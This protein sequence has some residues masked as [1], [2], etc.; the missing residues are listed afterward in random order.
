MG[1]PLCVKAAT[2]AHGLVLEAG[3]GERTPLEQAHEGIELRVETGDAGEVEAGEFLTRK[4]SPADQGCLFE[5]AERENVLGHAGTLHESA[6]ISGVRS[7]F[8]VR[9]LCRAGLAGCGIGSIGYAHA[10]DPER[11]LANT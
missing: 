9:A 2:R 5:R 4:G 6:P 1:S 10:C 11:V 7:W 8:F 3:S